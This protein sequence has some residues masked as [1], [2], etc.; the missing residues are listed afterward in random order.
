M[1]SST[2]WATSLTWSNQASNALSLAFWVLT[3]PMKACRIESSPSIC[4]MLCSKSVKTGAASTTSVVILSSA[5]SPRVR[6][7]FLRTTNRESAMFAF[8][9][10]HI[11]SERRFTSSSAIIRKESIPQ[12]D[13]QSHALAS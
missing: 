7:I 10:S 13:R 12:T 9:L 5:P 8:T 11:Y 4:F 3:W 2:S 1:M 6:A